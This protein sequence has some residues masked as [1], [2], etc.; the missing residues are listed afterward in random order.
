MI[1]ERKEAILFG[2]SAP[3]CKRSRAALQL[4]SPPAAQP[5]SAHF[6][7]A[8]NV[9]PAEYAIGPSAGLPRVMQMWCAA[10]SK[11]GETTQALTELQLVGLPLAVHA[12]SAAHRGCSTSQHCLS[13]RGS[14]GNTYNGC[15][16]RFLGVNSSKQGAAC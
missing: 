6:S 4:S 16:F 8:D 11:M 3:Q 2:K 7:S 14:H 5:L 15:Y 10:Y 1:D 9:L 12:A 13:Q